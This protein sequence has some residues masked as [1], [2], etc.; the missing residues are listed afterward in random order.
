[1]MCSLQKKQLRR[2]IWPVAAPARFRWVLSFAMPLLER[3][4][5]VGRRREVGALLRRPGRHELVAAEVARLAATAE[6]LDALGDDLDRLALAAVL[7]LPL[8]PVEAA[9]D[10]DGAA[11]REVLRAALRLVAED[12]DAEVVGLV[13]PL[14]RLVAAPA[15][16]RDAQAAHGSAARRVPQ[17]GVARQVPDEH[18]AVDVGHGTPPSPRANLCSSQRTRARG[19]R[20]LR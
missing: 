20:P 18:D 16:H 13:D 3:D 14:A 15:V 5:V 7:G 11:L 1:A 4:V 8:P 6:E 9:V 10:S 17:L 19:R 2:L 12:G